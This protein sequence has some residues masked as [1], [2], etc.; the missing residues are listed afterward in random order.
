MSILL[1]CARKIFLRYATWNSTL[2]ARS[3]KGF[4][5]VKVWRV[6]IHQTHFLGL[7]DIRMFRIQRSFT[8]LTVDETCGCVLLCLQRPFVI[9]V[10][11]WKE[12]ID[13]RL[14]KR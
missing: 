14:Q 6:L 13:V 11:T 2:K 1:I 12:H 4:V 10:T 8:W 5:F 7:S 3:N 9:H